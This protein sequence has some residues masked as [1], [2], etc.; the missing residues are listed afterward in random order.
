MIGTGGLDPGRFGGEPAVSD[1]GDLAG[2]LAVDVFNGIEGCQPSHGLC[3][4]L[5]DLATLLSRGGR[6][7]AEL[8]DHNE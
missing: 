5:Q 8:G 2:P 4:I 3:R 7:A 6:S 1:R